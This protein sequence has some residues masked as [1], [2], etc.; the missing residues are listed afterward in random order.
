[1]QL[2]HIKCK[3]L[4]NEAF[5]DATNHQKGTWKGNIKFNFSAQMDGYEA[6]AYDGN[7]NVVTWNGWSRTYNTLKKLAFPIFEVYGSTY[8]C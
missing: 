1:M 2:V 3:E 6:T 8:L 5:E 4:W 7:I